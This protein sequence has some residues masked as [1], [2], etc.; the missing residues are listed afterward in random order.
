MEI[1]RAREFLRH[2][3]R[4]VLHTHRK[5][6]SPQLS[7]ISC[8][9]DGSGRVVVS[10]REP[11]AKTRNVRRD[12]RVSLCVFGERFFGEWVQID[13]TAEVV[14][15]PEAMDGLVAYYRGIAGEHP[16][17]DDYRRA[18]TEEQRVLILVTIERAGPDYS[19]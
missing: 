17:W 8:G 14:S 1:E 11:A 16:D 2:N 5:D 9:L 18:M 10:T 19:G 4:A 7:P 6:G 13:G 3:H 12:P 15:L